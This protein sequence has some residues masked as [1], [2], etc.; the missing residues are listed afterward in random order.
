MD[1]LTY[2]KL[3]K[4]H[5]EIKMMS[6]PLRYGEIVLPADFI[7]VPFKL[8]RGTSGKVMHTHKIPNYMAYANKYYVDY[9]LGLDT[10]DGSEALPFKTIRGATDKISAGEPGDYVIICKTQFFARDEHFVSSNWVI[11]D[12]RVAIVSA[13]PTKKVYITSAQRDLRWTADEN[14]FKAAR[15]QIKAIFSRTELDAF[16][17]NVPLEN[18]TSLVDC[19]A[20]SNSWFTDGTSIWVNTGLAVAPTEDSHII[21]V[22]IGQFTIT[23]DYSDLYLENV[24]ILAG[25][26]SS[27]LTILTA[28][29]AAKEPNSSFTAKD[30]NFIGSNRIVGEITSGNG[31]SIVNIKTTLLFNCKS[32]H[33]NYDGFNYHYPGVD[34]AFVR[35]CLVVEYDCVSYMHG[36]L[37]TATSSNATT[38][39]EGISILRINSIG[40]ETHGPVL[41]DVNGCYSILID[42]KMRDSLLLNGSRSYAAFYF[43]STARSGGKALLINCEASGTGH[44]ISGDDLTPITVQGFKGKNINPEV[45]LEIQ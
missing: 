2:A 22:N 24:F 14:V 42:C 41:A 37:L 3:N 13:D 25:R 21:C 20:T 39:H 10:N 6:Y 27:G 32:A 5:K 23:L 35:S 19:K 29:N 8:Y 4:M 18:K 17:L 40:F 38:C 43:N 31:L 16:G 9:S 45:L 36:L 1:M 34:I 44:G 30:S 33:G 11:K 15:S 28:L 12:K 7:P 26:V